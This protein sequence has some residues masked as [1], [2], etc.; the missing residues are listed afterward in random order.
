M[1]LE[2]LDPAGPELARRWVAALLMVDKADRPA[3][4]AEIERRVTEAYPPEPGV[5]EELSVHQPAVQRDGYVEQVTTTY[6]V[7][8]PMTP[9]KKPARKRARGA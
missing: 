8:E 1:L 2:L 3:L 7:A 4:V 6:G 9:A 5:A